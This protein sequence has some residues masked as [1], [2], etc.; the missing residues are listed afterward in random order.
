MVTNE[1]SKL[2]KHDDLLQ[3]SAGDEEIVCRAIMCVFRAP[4]AHAP[5][6]VA[7]AGVRMLPPR[8]W[9]HTQWQHTGG[10]QR[11]RDCPDP[12]E[13]VTR[14]LRLIYSHDLFLLNQHALCF[15]YAQCTRPSDFDHWYFFIVTALAG[16]IY[17]L[18]FPYM[19]SNNVCDGNCP[20]E[21]Q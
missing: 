20:C 6:H 16:G 19:S 15:R 10:R 12:D 14:S 2:T 13:D 1:I 7:R 21:E 4:G 3:V 17:H 18:V 5:P 11:L 8:G 9:A